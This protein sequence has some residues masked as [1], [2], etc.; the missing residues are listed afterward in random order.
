MVPARLV[1]RSFLILT[2][3]LMCSSL[4]RAQQASGISGLVRD[5]S[6]AVLPGVNAA[7]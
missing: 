2:H 6:G 7:N 4:A 3:F 5:A 1:G